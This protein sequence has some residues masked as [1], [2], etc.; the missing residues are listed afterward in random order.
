[1]DLYFKRNDQEDQQRYFYVPSDGGA[2]FVCNKN[3]ASTWGYVEEYEIIEKIK[4][5][6]EKYFDFSKNM[7]DIGS[8]NGSYSILLNFNYTHC[9]DP[10]KASCCVLGTNMLM[11]NRVHNIEVHNIGLDT[12]PGELLFDGFSCADGNSIL[13]DNSNLYKIK[14]ETL[15]SFNLNN[16]GFIKID[17]EG[18]E[19]R[20]LRGAISTI[21]NNEYPP[22]LFEC[23]DVGY[24]GMTY[25]KHES[26]FN[27]LKTFNYIILEHWGD[28]ETHLAIHNN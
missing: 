9:F 26:L 2:F 27:F 18:M 15:D 10:N 21:I 8:E 3:Q 22:I 25:K 11:H 4:N 1:M 20:V 23:W 28:F 6:E 17:V 12:Y 13:I 7:I 14:V 5:N 16:I 19:E 24:C